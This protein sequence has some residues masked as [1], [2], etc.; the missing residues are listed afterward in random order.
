MNPRER[1]AVLLWVA[2]AGA[3]LASA[4]AEAGFRFVEA[5]SFLAGPDPAGMAV[6]DLNHD[7][8]LDVLAAND[9]GVPT[10]SVLLATGELQFAP[11]V[12]YPS[13][14]GGRT[15]RKSQPLATGDFNGDGHVDFVVT[16]QYGG[17]F[18]ISVSLGIGNGQ[19]QAGVLYQVGTC[20][21]SVSAADLD[22]DGVLDLA[23]NNFEGANVSVLLGNGD[24][25]F[26]PRTDFPASER[27]VSNVLADFDRDGHL[28]LASV[29]PVADVLVIMKGIGD[30]RFGPPVEFPV[31]DYPVS[32]VAG[33]FNRDAK[34]D[35]A[36][37]NG[38]SESISVL[39]GV[40]D[41]SFETAVDYQ[42]GHSGVP[43]SRPNS[44]ATADL[45][46]DGNPD[47][48]VADMDRGTIGLFR[49]GSDGYFEPVQL[50]AVAPQPTTVATADF[51]GDGSQDLGVLHSGSGGLFTLLLNDGVFDDSFD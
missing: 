18:H 34:P 6:V 10:V 31:A 14:P 3:L 28:D 50:L 9:G 46:H 42:V 48:V 5:G 51:D 32:L 20:P 47:L 15:G 37:A 40:G 27:P 1:S 24:G 39:L 2:L 17:P 19:F 38:G 33:D 35:V 22:H 13:A 25:T 41:G 4:D 23:V 45:D 7:G 8:R 29:D 12:A 16:T 49:G 11:P 36:V 30:G 44:V 43:F 26:R 21:T